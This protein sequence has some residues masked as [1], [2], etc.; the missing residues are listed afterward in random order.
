MILHTPRTAQKGG[1][2]R[3]THYSITT[4]SM[5]IK[6]VIGAIAFSLVATAGAA[7]AQTTSFVN[8]STNAATSSPSAGTNGAFLGTV[9][10]SAA[11]SGDFGNVSL[12]SVPVSLTT[13]SGATVGN[14]T[15]CQLFNA[16]GQAVTTGSNSIGTAGSSNTF[17]FD[18][19]LA[20][21]GGQSTTLTVRCNVASGT[22][23]GGTFQFSAGMPTY[24]AGLMANLNATPQV[25]PGTQ[26]ALLALVSLSATRSGS[27]IQVASL[28]LN[29][30]FNNGAM[31]GHITDCRVR[32]LTNLTSPL[33]NGGNA[34]GIVQGTNTLTFD[35]PLQIAAGSAATLAFTCDVSAS[36]PVGGSVG[37]SMTPSSLSSTVVGSATTVTPTA[38]F[39][40]NNQ[41]GATSG[42]V[43]FS[44]TAPD[45][46]TPTVPGVPNTGSGD[47]SQNLMIL[48][49][50]GLLAIAGV[51]ATRRLAIR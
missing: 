37:L 1:I 32:N 28:P 42:T 39:G 29:V 22:P 9:T 36:A 38:G 2:V 6:K 26:D 13:G 24:S 21:A 40:S 49:I 11:Q 14:L 19:P 20:I 8:V 43:A 31:A 16:S 44:N 25:R 4:K 30:T 3:I 23:T 10:L 18:S 45:P 33:N 48:A 34:V 17:T 27:A 51:Y 47:L 50:S 41:V 15:S 46:V 5:E 35:T 12:S 7:S